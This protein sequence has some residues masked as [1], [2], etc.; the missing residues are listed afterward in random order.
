[1]TNHTNQWDE[2]AEKYQAYFADDDRRTSSTVVFPRILEILGDIRGK[3][4]LDFGC[5][6][7][8]FS[9]AFYDRGAVVT[10][11]DRSKEELD[12]AAKLNDRRDILYSSE[13]NVLTNDTYDIVLCFMVLLCNGKKELC[14][15][16]KKIYNIAKGS[17]VC[18]FVNTNTA[19]LGRRFKDFYSIAP[20]NRENGAGYTTIIPT[21][22]GD[23]IIKDYFYTRDF[24]KE[25]FVAS[26]FKVVSEEVIRDQFV[27]HIARKG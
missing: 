27:L 8:R 26:G 7:G 14:K 12:I 16:V 18:I 20:D 6:Q 11:Y 9:R 21:S 5:G 19:T 2:N 17:G 22:E 23:I 1:M 3:K 4:I 13:R 25:V 24:L 10:G 15:M